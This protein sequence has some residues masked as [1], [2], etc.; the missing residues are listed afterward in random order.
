MYC[1]STVPRKYTFLAEGNQ[2]PR[3]AATVALQSENFCSPPDAP[4]TLLSY[5]AR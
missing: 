1:G 3:P 4:K 5:V 2:I